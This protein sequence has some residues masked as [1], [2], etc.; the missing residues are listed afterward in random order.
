MGDDDGE[1]G[2]FDGG[3]DD[4]DGYEEDGG[5]EMIGEGEE[6]VQQEY[7]EE[8][9]QQEYAEGEYAHAEGEYAEGQYYAQGGEYEQG[10]AEGEPGSSEMPQGGVPPEDEE[11]H[12][13][14]TDGFTAASCAEA[15]T[16]YKFI[17]LEDD[18]ICTCN[19]QIGSV[20]CRERML[21]VVLTFVVVSVDLRC[22]R[23][24]Y[25]HL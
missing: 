17:A 13:P 3:F 19:N 8:S 14:D 16:S 21:N 5:M 25:T 11:V 9:A 4:D 15:C 10:I 23:T 22:S 2:G 18:G 6:G 7:A 24:F 20:Q 1:G 12:G